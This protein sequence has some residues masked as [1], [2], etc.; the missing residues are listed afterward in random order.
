MARESGVGMSTR[1]AAW[2]SVA[3]LVVGFAVGLPLLALFGSGRAANYWAVYVLERS[4]SLDNVVVFLVVLNDFKIPI[5][6]R[7]R[8]V[9]AGIAGAIAVRAVAIA[10][11]AALI[12][13][14]SLL[15]Y[16]LGVL[17]LVMAIRTLHG[18]DEPRDLAN[19][20]ALRIVRR[21][22]PLTSDTSAGRFLAGSSHGWAVTPLGLAVLALVLVDLTF[23]IDS[24]SAAFGITTDFV[25]IWL[26]NAVALLGL[27]PLLALARALLR[28]FRYAPQ[29]FAA[30]LAFVALRLI[31]QDVVVIGPLESLVGITA[32]LVLGIAASLIGERVGSARGGCRQL[33]PRSDS[34]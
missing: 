19:S 18:S 16:A 2:L 12:G 17:L 3:W 14:L 4:L 13:R 21:V 34:R 30:I 32:I 9:H 27:V 23:A 7:L 26:A 10:A 6:Y 20:R 25:V 24:I 31:T 5:R 15:T 28:R 22:L 33:T 11:G 29:T 1:R 8:V